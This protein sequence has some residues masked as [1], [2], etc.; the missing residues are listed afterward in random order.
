MARRARPNAEQLFNKYDSH[1]L[2]EQQ[3]KQMASAIEAADPEVIRRGDVD[4]LVREY[5]DQFS[6]EAPSLIEGAISVNVEEAQVDVTGD[7]RFGAFD[8]G[9]TFVSGIRAAYYVPFSGERELFYCGASTRNLSIRPVELGKEELTFTYERPDQ[10]VSAT[11]VEFEK[12]LAQI[13][14]ALGWLGNDFRSFNA[15][16]PG[17]ARDMILARK[18]RVEQLAQGIESLGVPIRRTATAAAQGTAGRIKRESKP[19]EQYDVAL[20]F[21]GEN[22]TYVSQVAEGLKA[23]GVSVF[24]DQFEKAS[25]WGKDL[26]EHLAEIYGQ[27]SRFVVMFVSKEYVE[28]AW[29]THERRH[30]QDR[31]LL[32]QSEYILPARFDDTAVP[33]MTS[34]VGFVDLRHTSASELVA[35][36]LQKLGKSGH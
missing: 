5:A 12:E 31:A 13:K 20:S 33:G 27:R 18:G 7:F 28:K 8:D 21:A 24:Y 16:L 2:R 30:A 3:R 22:R 14:E 11:K 1:S 26:I 25:L 36:I 34:T 6:L 19:A 4:A 17:Q 32:A 9:P 10:D 15:S 23:A 29:T 35:L